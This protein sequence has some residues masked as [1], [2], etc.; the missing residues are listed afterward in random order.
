M[1][2]SPSINDYIGQVRL[3]VETAERKFDYDLRELHGSQ[4][5]RGQLRSG[6]TI[7][8]TLRLFEDQFAGLTDEIIAYLGKVVSRTRLDRDELLSV[9]SSMLS[10][11]LIGHKSLVDS[12]KL[13]KFAPGKSIEELIDASFAR[14]DQ[15][16]TMRLQEF[17][18]GLDDAAP[19]AQG[20]A[21]A[22][23]P[24][25]NRYVTPRDNERAAVAEALEQL[26]EHAR[27][28]NDVEDEDRQIA[29]SEIAAFEATIVQPRVS[30][31]LIQ[32]FVDMVLGWISK[33]FTAAAVQEVAQRLIQA[34]TK[35]LA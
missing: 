12:E 7:S 24:A 33:M 34:L 20:E 35:L 31:D 2:T 13:L 22:Y 25:S 23:V 1:A 21:G 18:F 32:R 29:L 4:G 14:A 10:Q 3:R 26:A 16:L 19:T 15:R 11:S 8:K 5:A 9:T 6:A 17:D 28:A 30:T 27:A